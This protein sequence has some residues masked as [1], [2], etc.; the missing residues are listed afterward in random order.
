MPRK[1]PA[2]PQ[3]LHSWEAS[4]WTWGEGHCDDEKSPDFAGECLV[5]L[6]L[7]QYHIGAIPAKLVCSVAWWAHHAGATGP[8]DNFMLSPDSSSGHFSRHLQH[9]LGVDLRTASHYHVDVPSYDKH[10]LSRSLRSTPML[11]PHELFDHECSE[12]VGYSE[13]LRLAAASNSLGPIYAEHPVVQHAD[14]P[15]S[16]VGVYLDSVPFLKRDSV[17]GLWV[18]N[19]ILQTRHVVALLRHSQMCRC[20]CGGYC[21]MH[22]IFTAFAWS[23][24]ALA[25]GRWPDC[26]HDGS[27]WLPDEAGYSKKGQPLRKAAV[28]EVRGDWAEFN[29]S[30]GFASWKTK[31]Y[32]CCFCH[33]SQEDWLDIRRVVVNDAPWMPL[34]DSDYDAACGLCEIKVTLRSRSDH[35]M[36]KAALEYDKRPDGSKGRSLRIDMEQFGLSKGDRLEPSAMLSDTGESFDRL[37]SFPV[38]L[39]FWRRSSETF[40]RRRCPL[41]NIPGLTLGTVHVDLMHTVDLGIG[42]AYSKHVVWA[43]FGSNAWGFKGTASEIDQLSLLA[44][45]HELF[46]WYKAQGDSLTGTPVQ[47]LTLSMFGSR[48]HRDL[49]MKAM[50]SRGFFAFAVELVKRHGKCLH[51]QHVLVEC[52]HALLDLLA[53]MKKSPRWPN[54]IVSQRMLSLGLRHIRLADA[55][56]ITL[57]PKH[58]LAIHMLREVPRTGNP[59]DVATYFDESLN[60]ILA[61]LGARAHARVWEHRV[62]AMFEAIAHS[63]GTKRCRE[64]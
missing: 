27:A 7:E 58:H 2:P 50:E 3:Q 5:E 24:A 26:K 53:L 37:V 10:S 57:L 11:L 6:L 49:K 64:D 20:G 47:D 13:A 23:M 44:M 45:R 9:A 18:Y 56:G 22:A 28:V 15:V 59:R 25:A 33:C 4:P 55:A 17:L 61:T 36:M 31:L 62:F 40:V 46:I 35:I 41:F 39:C 38:E 29:K 1:K 52:G 48:E 14:K 43:L 21:S 42:Q 16:P 32:P 30:L 60:G 54:Q 8:V 63:K 12:A 34:T 19:T 51:N